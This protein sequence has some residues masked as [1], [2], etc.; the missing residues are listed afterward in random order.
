MSANKIFLTSLYKGINPVLPKSSKGI[1]SSLS[2][3]CLRNPSG[4]FL[5]GSDNFLSVNAK[6]FT[7]GE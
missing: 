1:L 3:V 5:S 4:V 7:G 2:L 6:V